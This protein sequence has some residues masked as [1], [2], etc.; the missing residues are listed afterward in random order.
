M[1]GSRDRELLLTYRGQVATGEQEQ[2]QHM[3]SRRTKGLT[4][5]AGLAAVIA[6]GGNAGRGSKDAGPSAGDSAVTVTQSPYAAPP[7][8]TATSPRAS[9]TTP[10]TAPTTDPTSAPGP[11]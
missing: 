6:I 3:R 9:R 5:I 11:T 4:V 10:A 1:S 8:S 2:Q 7:V